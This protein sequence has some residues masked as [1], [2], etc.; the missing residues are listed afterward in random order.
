MVRAL[1]AIA[2]AVHRWTRAVPREMGAPE[3]A[4]DLVLEVPVDG[5]VPGL[6]VMEA[7]EENL[8]AVCVLMPADL[9]AV[10]D[11]RDLQT[12]LALAG[13]QQPFAIGELHARGVATLHGW[14]RMRAHE[15]EREG[16]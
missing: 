11:V 13:R 10:V 12:L 1:H 4:C 3:V 7:L 8:G 9:V 5:S 14:S 2:G 6:D 16:S 15:R